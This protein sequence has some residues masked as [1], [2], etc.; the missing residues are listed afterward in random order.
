LQRLGA[1]IGGTF[2]D[3]GRS[4]KKRLLGL[5]RGLKQDYG[6]K[7]QATRATVTTEV[8]AITERMVRHARRAQAQATQ[9]VHEHGESVSRQVTRRLHEL[10]TWLE[11]TE[12][13]IV[14]TTQVLAGDVHVKDRLISLFDPDARPIRK[15]NLRRPTEFGY[16]VCVTDEDRGFITDYE[17]SHGN[18]ADTTVLVPAIQRHIQRVGTVPKGVATDR[19][20][21]RPTNETALK[22]LGVTHCS[23]PKTGPKTVAEQTNER[24]HWFRR[25][26]R[27]RAGGEGRISLLK[28]KYGWRRSRLRGLEGVTTWVGWGAI[29]HNLAKYGQM[30]AAQA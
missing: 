27:F 20:M 12:R 18:P 19:G 25:L 30:Q 13:V 14:Q 10:T 5:G 16:K 9:W 29:A 2:R 22:Q 17:V 7:K 23:L 15:G 3:V 1:E 21:A 6:A 11:R 4:V 28:R 8:L 24:S 26:Q